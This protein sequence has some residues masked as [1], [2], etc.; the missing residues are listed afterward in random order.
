MKSESSTALVVLP[1]TVLGGAE[2]VM[3]TLVMELALQGWTVVVL[4]LT[5]RDGQ[6]WQN[7]PPSVKMHCLHMPREKAGLLLLPFFL[8]WLS[9]HYRFNR[10][11]TTHVHISAAVA[12]CRRWHFIKTPIHVIRESTVIADRFRG[13]RLRYFRL[14]YKQYGAPDL[15]ICQ[16]EYMQKRLISAVPNA[17]DWPTTVIPNPF[18]ITNAKN[19]LTYPPNSKWAA[20]QAPFIITVGRLI[21]EKGQDLLVDAFA[22]IH[23]IHPQLHLVIVGSGPLLAKVEDRASSLGLQHVIHLPGRIEK[24]FYLMTKSELGV[25]S[26][27]KEGFPNVL[28]EMMFACP[29]VVST[30]CA[31]D[32]ENI[33][34]IHHC[35][36]D[37]SRA[38][39]EAILEALKDPPNAS[40]EEKMRQLELRSPAAYLSHIERELQ[41]RV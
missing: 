19:A 6:L 27:R 37:S 8:F 13:F 31:G 11:F 2:H 38:L 41:I 17:K 7:M 20:P 39:A 1:G 32:I 22:K 15:V 28:L 16:T 12:V 33:N 24:P 18:S 10:V 34:G 36:P 21:Y 23:H 5:S 25:I 9:H 30:R 29:R 4:F 14:Q 35:E 3:Q 26:S 40:K